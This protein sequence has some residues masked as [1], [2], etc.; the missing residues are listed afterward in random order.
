MTEASSYPIAA[1]VAQ[2]IA[3]NGNVASN[4]YALTIDSTAPSIFISTRTPQTVNTA[5]FTLTGTADAGSVVD[6]R[7][8]GSSIGTAIATGGAWTIIVTLD[9][10]VNIFTA[11][12]TA[13]GG[14][15]GTGISGA[16]II[17]LDSVAP[18][19]VISSTSG[20]DGGTANTRTLSYTAIFDEAVSGFDTNDITV[21]GTANVGSPAVTRFSASADNRTYTFNVV[22]TNDGSVTVSIAA[23]VAQDIAGNG[24]VASNNYAL[25]IDSTAP[26]IFISTRTPQTVNTALFTLTGTADADSV[27]DVRKDGSSIGTAIATGGAWTFP[28]TLAEG[29]N[30]FTAAATAAGGTGGTGIS[31]AVIITLDSVAPSVVISSTSGGDGGTA[32]T[33]TLSYTAIFD[34]AVSGFDTN[35][36]T[37]TG[38]ASVGSP[39]VTRFSASADNRT[40]TFNVVATNDGSVTVSIAAGVAQDIAGNGNVASNN[41]ALTI[42]STAPSIFI[43]TRTPQTVNTALFTL[44]GTADADSVV[45][46][47]KDGS[48]I[49]TAIAT[50]GA[51]TIIVTLDE[52]VNIFTAAATAA[53]GTGGTGISGAVIITLDSVA[54]S[55]VISSTSGGDGGTANTRTL[56]YT[57]IFDEAVSGF[58]T[59][60][61]TVIGSA[62]V[63]SP[64]V[65]RFSASADN[66]TY[67][68]NVVATNDGSVIVSIAAESAQDIAGNGNVASNNYALT[69][70]STAPS[71][72][73]S[74]RTPQTVNT[75]LFTLTGTADAGSVVDIRK[76]GSS[77]GT[78]IATGGAWT[79]IVTLDEGVNIF[80]AAATAAGGTGGTGI[81]G[82]V[83][84]TLDSVA[85]SVVI[86]STS[87]GDGGTANTRT[88]SYTAIFDEAVSGFDEGDITVTGTAISGSATATVIS[89][90]SATDSRTYTFNVEATSDGSVIVSIAAGVA[91]DIAGNGN[92]ASNNYALTIDSTA[93][94]IFI[95][96]RTPQTVNTALFTLTGT[97][98]AG[99]VVDVRKDGSSIG[100]AIA[101]GGAWTIIVTLD[102]GV[103]IFTAAAAGGTGGTGISGAVIITLDSVAPSVVISSTSGGDGGTA[104]TRT[105]SYTAIFD[106]AVSG[107]DTNDITVIGSANVGSPAVTRFSAS[108][109]NR[110]Y[111]FNVVATT[112]GSVT[113]SI[114]AGVA[115]DIAGNGNVAS[116]NYA[117]TIDSTAPS[118]FISTR[119]PQTVNTA[120]FTLTGTADAD[121]V[122]DVR[123]D[124]SSIGTAIATGGA[125]TFPVTLAEGVNIFTASRNRS[126]WHW[127]YRNIRSRYHHAGQCCAERSHL[128]YFWR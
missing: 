58:D 66:R 106:E 10:G 42:D 63:G 87:G 4:N 99:S 100:T 43:S 102:E 120:L 55:V 8:D 41:Y 92:V 128:I 20:G 70:D 113:V 48:S 116:N 27:V 124:G 97:A 98:D 11:A 24:N 96:T 52:G 19:V 127:G 94:S 86:S 117:L 18:S 33:R 104:N 90:F 37:V 54:P 51:W 125:W 60:D 76:D 107:F 53:G 62:S 81:S 40:Y 73:I 118:I 103:N 3:G 38:S 77:I 45:D 67:T 64:A 71:I 30:I 108:A 119:T 15:G 111:T 112:D 84:I 5:L 7:K 12:A 114:A 16:V 83:I 126:W 121:S 17:T 79:I 50:G 35:D 49:G 115:Q 25:T 1:G 88:L 21:I 22:A 56:S 34:E 29:V 105:L 57:A 59:N 39:A 89:G 46:V 31:G 2:D 65:T 78:A 85:P 32:N 122:V 26:S 28:V 74:T 6:V 75:A 9:E 123:K 61:I 72:F 23:G 101:T 93:P 82:A 80:T 69:I 36:I 110:T 13:A 91:Q 109:D 95:S 68:F 47:R 14:T 44:T